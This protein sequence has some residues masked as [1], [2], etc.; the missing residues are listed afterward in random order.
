MEFLNYLTS[1][2]P[3]FA[4]SAIMIFL[5]FRNLRFK[6]VESILFLVFTTI[7]L[8]LSV[9]VEFENYSQ[10]AGLPVL[11]T[12]FT[13][14]GYILRPTLLYIF[15][16]LANMDFKRS[17]KFYYLCS[18]PLLV[19]IFVYLLPLFI[20]VPG[21]STLV[22]Y[23]QANADGTASFMRGTFLN[24][25][26]HI[27]SAFYLVIL[28]YVS[29]ARFHSKH[30]LDGLVII[31]CVF[32]ITVTVVAEM[33]ADRNDLLN[34][35]CEICALTNYV[36]LLSVNSSKD[37]LTGLYDR[38]TFDQDYHKHTDSI[39]GI[40]RIGMND[41]KQ[42]NDSYGH[43]AGDYAISEVSN[44]IAACVDNSSMCLYRLG[45]G[46][47]IILMFDGMKKSL[48]KSEANIRLKIKNTEYSVAIGSIYF[49]PK[50][51]EISIDDAFK[52]V[53]EDM[54]LDR[55]NYFRLSGRGRRAE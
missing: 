12:I 35:I 34:I 4:I 24:F 51:G 47:F 11:G 30:K 29:T 20:G 44:I 3:L 48:E 22:F 52:R 28:I 14:I 43:N 13:S 40:I 17:K 38:K 55:S 31:L 27:I 25:F 5:A 41:L 54:Y 1:N 10:D 50:A 9:V 49:D 46:E 23:Y 37:Q 6:R 7:V 33:V 42:L 26:S 21:I 15:T 16:L 45:G 39:N 32:F 8:F 18:I 19:N 2:I 36:F 53:E